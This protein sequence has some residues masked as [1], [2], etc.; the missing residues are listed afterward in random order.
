M[1]YKY[2]SWGAIG[3]LLAIVAVAVVAFVAAITVIPPAINTAMNPPTATA[4]PTPTPGPCSLSEYGVPGSLTATGTITIPFNGGQLKLVCEN[5]SAN[6]QT[7]KLPTG[8]CWIDQA[9][10]RAI[11]EGQ[12]RE[13]NGE[14]WTCTDGNLIADNAVPPAPTSTVVPNIG[15][16]VGDKT[17]PDGGFF[18][19][20]DGLRYKCVHGAKELQVQTI[21][22]AIPTATIAPPPTAQATSAPAPFAFCALPSPDGFG[23]A[24]AYQPADTSPAGS[25]YTCRNNGQGSYIWVN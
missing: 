21:P 23:N 9:N 2:P 15:C 3:L 14:M 1:K 7:L 13:I 17:V 24:G 20:S 19:E 11:L 22:T 8:G 5:S 12:K 4:I 25:V 18:T 16:F 6:I 10:N